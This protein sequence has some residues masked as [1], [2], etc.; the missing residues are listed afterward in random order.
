GYRVKRRRTPALSARD[1]L[2]G[3]R[4]DAVR[5]LRDRLP[6][7]RR[8]LADLL[9]DALRRGPAPLLLD[10]RDLLHLGADLLPLRFLDG[11]EGLDAVWIE[12]RARHALHLVDGRR[13]RLRLAV[14][15]LAGVGV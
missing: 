10:E 3:L 11:A 6:L 1:R 13:V 4:I 12:L 14:G 8:R 5:R 7:L 2:T 15:P 9:E